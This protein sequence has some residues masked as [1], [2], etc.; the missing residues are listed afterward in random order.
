MLLI[1]GDASATYVDVSNGEFAGYE[2][3]VIACYEDSPDVPSDATH[4]EN[5]L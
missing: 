5:G 4:L 3:S 1:L 2:I